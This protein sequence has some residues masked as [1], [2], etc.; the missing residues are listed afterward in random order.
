MDRINEV[1]KSP[2]QPS[3]C[4]ISLNIREDQSEK[5]KDSEEATTYTLPRISI[6]SPSSDSYKEEVGDHLGDLESYLPKKK[7]DTKMDSSL[8]CYSILLKSSMSS[9]IDISMLIQLDEKDSAKRDDSVQYLSMKGESAGMEFKEIHTDDKTSDT[10][11]LR[12]FKENHSTNSKKDFDETGSSHSNSSTPRAF[13][14]LSYLSANSFGKVGIAKQPISNTNNIPSRFCSSKEEVEKLI[15]IPKDSIIPNETSHNHFD[16]HENQSERQGNIK[17]KQK[18]Q[19]RTSNKSFG[20]QQEKKLLSSHRLNSLSDSSLPKFSPVS[21]SSLQKEAGLSSNKSFSHPINSSRPQVLASISHDPLHQ[22]QFTSLCTPDKSSGSFHNS[23]S[24]KTTEPTENFNDKLISNIS[25]IRLRPFIPSCR[26]ME[27]EEKSSCTLDIPALTDRT[28][29]IVAQNKLVTEHNSD[30]RKYS[31]FD[32]KES[33]DHSDRKLKD[34]I[35]PSSFLKLI[36]SPK[37][38][39]YKRKSLS[40]PQAS[41]DSSLSESSSSSSSPSYAS[42]SSTSTSTVPSSSLSSPSSSSL[43]PISF[44]SSNTSCISHHC[45]HRHRNRC[46]Y[47]H[48]KK[49]YHLHL[50][51]SHSKRKHKH[52]HADHSLRSHNLIHQIK[53]SSYPSTTF[54]TPHVSKRLISHDKNEKRFKTLNDSQISEKEESSENTTQK[55][56]SE[57]VNVPPAGGSNAF[58]IESHGCFKSAMQSSHLNMQSP[59][60]SGGTR[61]IRSASFDASSK[62]ISHSQ[63]DYCLPLDHSPY[64]R[65]SQTQFQLHPL[66]SS[67]HFSSSSFLPS[68]STL[69]SPLSTVNVPINAQLN[70]SPLPPLPPPSRQ[71]TFS[72]SSPSNKQLL[73]LSQKHFENQRDSVTSLPNM[74]SID[75]FV[76]H[77]NSYGF[78]SN[79]NSSSISI[80]PQHSSP[81]T[82]SSVDHCSFKSQLNILPS[83]NTSSVFEQMDAEKCSSDASFEEFQHKDNLCSNS[84]LKIPNNES[85]DCPISEFGQNQTSLQRSKK[86]EMKKPQTGIQNFS[87]E[88]PSL[89]SK[90]PPSSS[91]FKATSFPLTAMHPFQMKKTHMI[92]KSPYSESASTIYPSYE[93]TDAVG[94]SDYSILKDDKK[95]FLEEKKRSDSSVELTSPYTPILTQKKPHEPTAIED[96]ISGDLFDL[97]QDEGS[98]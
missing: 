51:H 80:I 81:E 28:A 60:L 50:H 59:T 11:K 19:T 82:S 65:N 67:S 63:R 6:S 39:T 56:S 90:L 38:E 58:Q 75:S 14:E 42:L 47:Y 17:K 91:D 88:F 49:H 40:P 93:E 32:E 74:L 9:H 52:E 92:F 33:S 43:T 22:S 44:S 12:F 64:V 41:L 79:C 10:E 36:N 48:R 8:K 15:S 18:I 87:F 54:R 83:S 5:R 30:T 37:N 3:L 27:D 34:D 20:N 45:H 84:A 69:S 71:R 55:I 21:D 46:N 13:E 96:Q 7:S 4:S 26:K 95:S 2:S 73:Q 98:F 85:E 72:L 78:Q 57:I 23:N 1:G 61:M 70:H 29:P 62:T 89:D 53:T 97:T 16:K 68:T 77:P 24:E 86:N 31:T 35:M 76:S 66:L 25:E 94:S